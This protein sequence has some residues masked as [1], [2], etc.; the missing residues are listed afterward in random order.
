ML[1]IDAI[2]AGHGLKWTLLTISHPPFP[3]LAARTP[4][5]LWSVKNGHA[6]VAKYLIEKGADVEAAGLGGMRCL[7]VASA[8]IKEGLV[9]L[10][11][12]KGA[13]PDSED[14][15][16]NSAMHWACTR[17]VLNI[18][19]RLIE[20]GASVK[21]ANKQGATALHKAS[22]FGQVGTTRATGAALRRLPLL[23]LHSAAPLPRG[24]H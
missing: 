16:G 10:L 13:D 22:G 9:A 2:M 17:G 20:K 6:E 18:V 12:E 8:N 23:Q 21:A 5:K 7:H 19:I 3:L 15:A 11:L 14:D 24:P 1:A 4:W